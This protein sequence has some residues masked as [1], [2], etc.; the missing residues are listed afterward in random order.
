MSAT[1]DEIR[2]KPSPRIGFHYFPDTDHYSQSDLST[3][4][5][6]LKTLNAHWLV[7]DTD[8]LRAIPEQF[9]TGLIA[10]GILPILHL[11]M[12]LPNSP[13]AGDMKTLFTAYARW[14]VKHL[15][16]FDRPNQRENWSPAGWT[17]PDLVERFVD[18]FLPLAV[19]VAQFGMMPIFPPPQPGGDYWDVAFLK[20]SLQSMIRRGYAKLIDQIGLS[21]Y[22]FTYGHDLDFGSGGPERWPK[23]MPYG[24]SAESEDQK[25]FRNFEWL[26]SAAVSTC[27]NELPMFLLGA[28]IKEPGGN[29]S[30]EMHMG[31]NLNILE[32]LNSSTGEDSIPTYV[33]SCNFFV[34]STAANSPLAQHA[35]FRSEEDY[36]P[37]VDLLIPSSRSLPSTPPWNKDKFTSAENLNSPSAESHPIAHYLLLPLY[38][39]GVADFHLEVIRP[40]LQKYHPTIGFSIE[41]ASLA[42][43]ITVLGGEQSFPEDRLTALRNA[44]CNVE[45][46]CGDGMSIATQLAE[47]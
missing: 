8:T 5:P 6:I 34:L 28:G 35:W 26:Q 41:E 17:Q 10:D 21:S 25:G 4:L 42:R 32:Q 3:W 47:R 44:G 27:H 40:F 24:K 43:K 37:I 20:Q 36:L 16:L 29:L 23:S 7:L 33:Q 11:H 2:T 12:A 46:I 19:S 22:V 14:G 13:T 39:W 31:L 9:I 15:I 45:R 30:P 1:L 18:R 38:E